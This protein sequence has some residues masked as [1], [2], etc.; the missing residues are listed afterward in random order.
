MTIA[1]LSLLTA[2]ATLINHGVLELPGLGNPGGE[3]TYVETTWNGGADLT[4]LQK[5]NTDGTGFDQSPGIGGYTFTPDG[6]VATSTVTWDMSVNNPG[7]LGLSYILLKDGS[8][9][10]GS[11]NTLYHLYGIGADMASNGSASL[12]INGLK[13]ISHYT[14]FGAEING[15]PPPPPPPPPPNGVPE[16]GTSVLMLGLSL[17]GLGVLRRRFRK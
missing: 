16:G 10:G 17:I 14:F 3:E 6:N 9:G 8:A 2:E 12:T 1:A 11:G 15:P 4:Y 13:G 5:W 7:G